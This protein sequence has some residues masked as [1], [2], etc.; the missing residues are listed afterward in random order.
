MTTSFL[1][2]PRTYD[3]SLLARDL[4][5][6]IAENWKS[7]FNTQDYSG[8]WKALALYSASGAADDIGTAPV[9][10]FRPTPLLAR[11]GYFREIIESFQCPREAI[12]LLQLAPGSVVHEHRDRQLGYEFGSLRLHVPIQTNDEVDFVVGGQRLDMKGGE[13]WYA[14]FDLPHSVV[15][16][17]QRARVHLVID[18]KRN[19]WTDDLFRSAGY[20]FEAERAAQKPDPETRRLMMAELEKMDTEGARMLLK[21]MRAEEF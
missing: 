1:R 17:G 15:N 18:L 16:R 20:D 11:C 7:H 5:V 3:T 4:E 10:E 19:E 12:R 2:L 6:C 13:L 21:Q 9:G 8:D 14:N